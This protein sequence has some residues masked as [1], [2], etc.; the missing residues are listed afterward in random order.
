MG[1]DTTKKSVAI[2][3]SL[4]SSSQFATSI[5]WKSRSFDKASYFEAYLRRESLARGHPNSMNAKMCFL[6]LKGFAEASEDRRSRNQANAGE[7]AMHIFE[8]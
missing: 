3:A 6:Y 5:V 2:R 7:E 1:G 4:D 8:C